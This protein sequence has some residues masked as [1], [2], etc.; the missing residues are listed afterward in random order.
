MFLEWP[1]SVQMA[2]RFVIVHFTYSGSTLFPPESGGARTPGIYTS[3]FG[4]PICFPCS[5]A[6]FAEYYSRS[7]LGLGSLL[8]LPML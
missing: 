6:G 4:A 8:S 1:L 2:Q 7:F 3:W 5:T